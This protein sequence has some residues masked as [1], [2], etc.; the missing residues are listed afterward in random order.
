MATSTNAMEQDMKKAKVFVIRTEG[1]MYRCAPVD[2]GITR[3]DFKSAISDFEQRKPLY[4]KP[5]ELA[6]A[7]HAVDV[8]WKGDKR[9]GF[10][11]VGVEGR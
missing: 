10:K 7:R 2:Q 9:Y 8:V 3:A 4:A 1:T 11:H 6:N 5:H